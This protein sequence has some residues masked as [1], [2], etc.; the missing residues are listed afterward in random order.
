MLGIP[1]PYAGHTYTPCWA[2]LHPMPG[3]PTPHAGHRYMVS[4][5]GRI[6][7]LGIGMC[8]QGIGG[9]KGC[10]SRGGDCPN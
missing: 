5:R 10:F 8:G 7:V 1:T 6:G 9:I 2:Y 3:I 4:P